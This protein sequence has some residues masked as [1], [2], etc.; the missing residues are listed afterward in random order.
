VSPAPEPGRGLRALP[1]ALLAVALV[2]LFVRVPFLVADCAGRLPDAW[3]QAGAALTQPRAALVEAAIGVTPTVERLLRERLPEDGRLVVYSPYRGEVAEY[4][5]RTQFERLKNL[6][7]PAP[8]DAHFAL[9]ADDLRR[10]LE[11]RFAGKLV[12]VDGTQED[13]PLP[14]PGEFELLADQRLGGAM[15]VRYWL[16]REAGR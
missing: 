4:L 3:R 11:A 6:L 5:V 15:R 10:R 12:V 14:A 2:W 7:Y 8:R 16:L 13:T 1:L 9:D